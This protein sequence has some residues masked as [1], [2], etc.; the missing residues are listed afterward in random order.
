VN[1]DWDYFLRAQSGDNTSWR[2]LV[3]KYQTRLTALALLI[4][5]SSSVADD[6]VQETFVKAF[7]SRV[8][9]MKGA[10]SGYLGTIAYRLALKESKRIK[11]HVEI[12][13]IDI[14]DAHADPLENVLINE[15]DR[16]VASVINKLENDH[17]DIVLLRFYADN[18]YEEI[19]DILNIP[20]GTVKSRIFYAV[21]TCRELL[22]NKGVHNEPYR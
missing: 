13:E 4:T 10:V 15:R 19:A 11:R 7:A 22:K 1:S 9:D 16:I 14:E 3:E 18:S 12:D 21:K 6:I 2:V 17:R 20:I 8:K 5:S